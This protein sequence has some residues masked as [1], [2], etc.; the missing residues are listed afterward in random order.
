MFWVLPA[1]PLAYVESQTLRLAEHTQSDSI[2]NALFIH[3]EIQR[4]GEQQQRPP[5]VKNRDSKN[6][7]SETVSGVLQSGLRSKSRQVKAAQISCQL[8]DVL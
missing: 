3:R 1:L 2:C 4:Q 5:R 6:I 7:I 8:A